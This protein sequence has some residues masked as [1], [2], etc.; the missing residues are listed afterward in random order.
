M[1]LDVIIVLMAIVFG[2]INGSYFALSHTNLGSI[3]KNLY[4][5]IF[6]VVAVYMSAIAILFSIYSA[7]TK[8]VSHQ[9]ITGAA[10]ISIAFLS[11][12]TAFFLVYSFFTELKPITVKHR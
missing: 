5:Q 3:I 10:H 6:M 8:V 9:F 12:S 2:V 11:Y 7:H 1:E 4:F